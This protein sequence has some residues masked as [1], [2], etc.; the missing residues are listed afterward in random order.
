[1]RVPRSTLLLLALT[2]CEHTTPFVPGV[3]TPTGPLGAG[4][5]V[6]LTYSSGVD[7]RPVWLPSGNAFLYSQEQFGGLTGADRDRCLAQMSG[8]GGTITREF[9]VTTDPLHDSLNALE[10]PA[11]AGDGRMVYLRT[12]ML[13]FLGRVGAD[14]S[15]LV[16]ATLAG[17]L[18]GT[19]VQVVPFF[20]TTSHRSVDVV[21]DVQWLGANAVVFLAEQ[22]TYPAPCGSCT[23]DTVR[24]GIEVDLLD[25]STNPPVVSL[26]PNTDQASSVAVVGGD[27][28]Y[29]TLN[30]SSMVLRRVGVAGTDTVI[31]DFGAA[32]PATDVTV[33]GGRI[34]A[35]VNGVLHLVTLA[36]GTDSIISDLQ[37]IV[38]HP[39]F[40]PGGNR[41]V[42]EVVP[43]VAPT[44]SSD[45]WLWTL[46]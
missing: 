29:H 35:V 1:M 14:H 12:S 19:V 21:S 4:N 40:A 16:L 43:S 38:R 3:Y 33:A 25:L 5:P 41:L 31:F 36:T 15:A 11:V 23:P 20:D 26:V 45:L 18:P 7:E 9:C 2:A 32:G 28:L 34:A 30:G 22:A 13:A 27:T 39:A 46:P 17:P 24:A 8:G 37:T 44:S 6:R 10:S 42:A